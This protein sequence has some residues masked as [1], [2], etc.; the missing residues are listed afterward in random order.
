MNG[1]RGE[2]GSSTRKTGRMEAKRLVTECLLA[3][4]EVTCSRDYF[5]LQKS[6]KTTSHLVPPSLPSF[7]LQHT[8]AEREK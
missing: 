8:A 5:I 2:A 1:K 4:N 3:D 7:R 6:E